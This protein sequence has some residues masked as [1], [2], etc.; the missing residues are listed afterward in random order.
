MK[1]LKLLVVLFLVV[2]I[3]SITLKTASESLLH[4]RAEEAP[5][6]QTF[7]YNFDVSRP[8][9]SS[10]R[11]PFNYEYS[12]TFN[13]TVLKLNNGAWLE[14]PISVDAITDNTSYEVSLKF[15]DDG[16]TNGGFLFAVRQDDL[17][18]IGIGV[19]SYYS[20]SQYYYRI[21]N[22]GKDTVLNSGLNRSK[23]VKSQSF[24]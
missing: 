16:S 1:T 9:W 10:A 19:N 22:N 14:L 4:R 17:N 15:Y 21:N 7:Y 23:G 11:R 20:P 8:T 6:S 5:A 13:S 12:T 3:F 2:S 24:V 18:A